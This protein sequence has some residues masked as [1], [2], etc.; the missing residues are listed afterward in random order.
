MTRTSDIPVLQLKQVGDG[1]TLRVTACGQMK[2][3]T[4]PEV[5][6]T[7]VVESGE[8]VAV[9]LPLKSADRQLDRLGL[10]YET[11][12]GETLTFARSDSGDPKKPFWDVV[13]AD[14]P[15][16]APVRVPAKQAAAKTAPAK[17]AASEP[18]P[19]RRE[20]QEAAH[21]KK[22]GAALYLELTE[23]TLTRVADLYKKHGINVTME[24]V[25]ACVATQFIQANR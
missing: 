8:T 4:Y 16:D 24:G 2:I 1:A 7:G 20:Q 22:K 6:F 15:I 17:A 19:T 5:E 3:G 10:D 13:R 21:P 23:F 12:I 11:A 18:A 25:A 9:R 14:E